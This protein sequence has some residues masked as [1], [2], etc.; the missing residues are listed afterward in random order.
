MRKRVGNKEKAILEAAIQVFAKHGYNRAKISTIAQEAGVATGSVYLYYQNKEGIL[1]TIFDQLWSNCTRNLR[2]TVKRTDIDPSQKL[3]VVIDNFF[4][5]FISN[6]HIATVFVNEQH[7]LIQNKRGNVATHYNEF[8]DLAEDIIREGVQKKMY[9]ENADIRLLRH[10]ITGG[11]RNVLQ[12]W[13]QQPQILP[14]DH[15]RKN[16]KHY[17]KH[18]L[19]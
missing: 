6:Q 19:L 15:I 5:L 16:V 10:F 12:Q 11:L 8:F 2:E 13:A 17:I 1:L 7:K 4:D 14:L 18:G 9:N 3:D